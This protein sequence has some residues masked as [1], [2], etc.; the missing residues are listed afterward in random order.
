M[1]ARTA[2]IT[3]STDPKAIGFTAAFLL[4]SQKGFN[5]ILAG[6]RADAAK[7]AADELTKKL[8]DAASKSKVGMQLCLHSPVLLY[9]EL[10]WRLQVFP[11]TL[12]VTSEQ[13]IQ[14]AVAHLSSAEG[15]L[16]AS[17]GA[18][19][20]LINNAGVGAPPGRGGK[21]TNNM[22]L[23]TELTTAEDMVTV[24]TTNVAA[25]VQVT[26]G[27][28][29]SRPLSLRRKFLTDCLSCSQ[30][31]LFPC[32]PSRRRHASSTSHLPA[33]RSRLARA[34]SPLARVPWCTTRPRRPSVGVFRGCRAHCSTRECC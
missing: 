9:A 17:Q 29:S 32:W 26:S 11:L 23:Q 14:A 6:R 18:L 28:G 24:L 12:D 5:V 2:L 19:D 8:A 27:L 13:S 10:M 21:G 22:F 34:S 16:A 15:P 4:A 7:A 20:V 31:P 25:V 3:G 30:T 1:A 33:A